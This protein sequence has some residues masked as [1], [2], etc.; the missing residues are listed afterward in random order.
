MPTPFV[1]LHLHSEFSLVDGT[2]RIKPLIEKALEMGMPAIAITDQHNLFA[3]VKFYRA[4]EAAGIKPIIGA[5]VLLRHPDNPDHI[6]RLVLLCQDRTGYLNLC[7][8]LS[9]GYTE[10]QHHG[11]PYLRNDWIARSADGLIALSAGREG[12]I[13]QA[14]LNNH[15]NRARQLAE[16]WMRLFPDRFYI[17]IQ[18]SGREQEQAYETAALHLASKLGLPVIASNDVR[19]LD[20]SHFYA[21]EARVCI[22]DGRLLSDKRRERRYSE[23]QYFKSPEEMQEL[24]SDLPEALENTMHLAQR[25]NLEMEFDTYHLP[26]FPTPDQLDV[27]TFL[28][29]ESEAGL[30]DRLKQFAAT[31][32]YPE[33]EYAARLDLELGVINSM[34]FPGY[35]LIVAD[36]IHW[37]KKN[38]I[39]VGPGRGSGAGSLV[40]YALGITDL[41]PLV[42]EL[43]FERFLNPERVSMP[44]FDIDFCM[45]K[46]DLVID[47]VARTYGRD[48]VSQII[49]FGSMAA[50]AVVR[51]CGRVL[52][53][54]Y[55]FVDSIAKLIPMTLGITLEQAL[56]EE[57]QL[58]KRFDDEEDTRAILDLAMS[59]EGLKR[60][61]GKHAGGVVIAPSKLT[62]FAPLFCEAGG[63]SIVTQFD[64]N[65]VET[66]GLVKFDFL[67]LRTLTII[68]WA[69]KTI[70]RQRSDSHKAPI[71]LSQLPMDD[72]ETFRLLQ[73]CQTTAVFQLESRG[74]KDLI[75]K[76]VPDSFAEIV[77]LVALF[78]PG[79]L[80]SG[81]VGD[82]IDRKHGRSVVV[83]PHPELEPILKPTYGVILYQEQ[84]MEIARVLGGYTLGA[85]D[86]LRRA[87]G[88]KDPAEMARQRLVFVEGA[89]E[90]AVDEDLANLIFDQMETFAGYG[91]NK[92]HSAAYALIAYQ[93]AWLKVHHQAAFMAAVLSSDM[94]TTDKVDDFI[95]E[96]RD[97]GLTVLPPDINTS[98]H[99]FT[100]QDDSTIGY[101]LGA[102]K[103]VGHAAIDIIENEREAHG[104]YKDLA[105][106]CTRMDLQKVNRRAMDVLIRSGSMDTL[107]PD[108]NRA[109]MLHELPGALQAAEQSQRDR[110][111]GQSDMFGS[112][113][114]GGAG[115][116]SD[117]QS[118]HTIEHQAIRPWTRLQGL[119]GERDTLG[120]Y[121]T[122]HPV[123]LQM[124][125]L[126]HFATCKLGDIE[127]RMPDEAK[128]TR[129]GTPMVL[130]GLVRAIRRRGSRGGFVSIEDHSGRV[131]VALFDEAWSLYADM[132]NK[133]E[134]IVIDGRVSPNDFSGGFRMTAQK[135]MTLSDAKSRFAR[136]IQISL[137]GPDE[138]IC[139]ALQSTFLPYQN[140]SGL[141][142]LDYS[143]A[144]ARARLELSE[145]FGVKACAE[146]VAALSDLETVS[147][148]RLIY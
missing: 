133:D 3:M 9:R 50:K 120:L 129:R 28:R 35:F 101:G 92:S 7:E 147:D 20:K 112:V 43:L 41:D 29:Q 107:D 57:P 16:D 124:Q 99:A 145:E 21:H 73:S 121:L 5:D 72:P 66:I 34:G 23:E 94:D 125:D 18:R 22:H 100:V 106:F 70:N 88:K 27:E 8:L 130:A 136:G 53:N 49:T 1:H 135:V 98:H 91:F 114:F 148:A 6:S 79:P 146:L 80:E 137:R 32:Q 116:G 58:K 89:V 144:R 126:S 42:H 51:D 62:D 45:E 69:L 39:P 31:L 104:V 15:P 61:A 56:K 52:G 109:R 77:A 67:G 85:A 46:R 71:E 128:G 95:H 54:G 78:R 111:S 103:G 13:G 134:I 131:E 68:D 59:L 110:E 81:M 19:F 17:E 65:D 90:R 47:Y 64:K 83:Y 141:V 139:A 24:F 97:L 132:L 33:E 82:Y 138:D 74:M 102:L 105:D 113:G 143:N 63:G 10:G 117:M 11:I 38:D 75:R 25:C 76:L 60:N 2:V 37:A 84:V 30:K 36:F 87:M 108:Q 26:D 142:W 115:T 86:I 55:G 123:E 118:P 44:D 12:D 14:L 122:G 96:C 140:G 127:A 48:Q 119:Q 93:T 4:A 40:A